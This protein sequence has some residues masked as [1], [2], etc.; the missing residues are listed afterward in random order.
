MDLV[1]ISIRNEV[2]HL[3]LEQHITSVMQLTYCT[4]CCS[5]SQQVNFDQ[6]QHCSPCACLRRMSYTFGLSI[7]SSSTLSSFSVARVSLLHVVSNKTC[8]INV[9]GSN[10]KLNKIIPLVFFVFPFLFC[11]LVV[12]GVGRIRSAADDNTITQVTRL[13][14]TST[15]SQRN[16]EDTGHVYCHCI[17]SALSYRFNLLI[18]SPHQPLF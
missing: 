8:A 12:E 14:R 18:L 1:F 17:V 4:K 6:T 13:D 10:K 7:R 11:T 2:D 15:Y 5:C 3:L 16:R 9:V